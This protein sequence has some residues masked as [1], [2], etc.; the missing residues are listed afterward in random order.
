MMR[1]AITGWLSLIFACAF[2]VSAVSA[3]HRESTAREDAV[4][5]QPAV[6]AA[7]PEWDEALVQR[8][9]AA[10]REYCI[11]CHD[12]EKSLGKR[13]SLSKWRAT[14]TRMATKDDANIPGNEREAIAAIRKLKAEGVEAVEIGR[15]H[16]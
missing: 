15:A 3:Q 2:A 14:I 5:K 1:P 9:S 7:A 13:K 8:G 10:F 16:V 6:D 11:S 4:A 12:A